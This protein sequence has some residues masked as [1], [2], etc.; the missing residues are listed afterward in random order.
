MYKL[1][2]KTEAQQKAI[3]STLSVEEIDMVGI[4]IIGKRCPT[5]RTI[6]SSQKKQIIF[7]AKVD[8]HMVDIDAIFVQVMAATTQPNTP[9]YVRRHGRTL[10]NNIYDLPEVRSGYESVLSLEARSNPSYKPTPD[11]YNPRQF[12]GEHIIRTAHDNKE[13][14]NRFVLSTML[15][16]GMHTHRVTKSENKLLRPFQKVGT[17]VDSMSSYKDAGIKLSMVADYVGRE[18]FIAA[19]EQYRIEFNRNV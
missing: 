10:A 16:E 2:E 8:S 7:N 9:A 1:L 11:H 12:M 13:N 15:Y 19:I 17:F 14:F 18:S 6:L 3:I 4:D 5:L